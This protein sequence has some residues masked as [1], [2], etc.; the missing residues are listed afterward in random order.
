MESAL[1][2]W[3]EIRCA[4][5]GWRMYSSRRRVRVREKKALVWFV[6]NCCVVDV[7]GIAVFQRLLPDSGP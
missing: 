1:N 7:S 5:C 2:R 6:G 3:E 4:W